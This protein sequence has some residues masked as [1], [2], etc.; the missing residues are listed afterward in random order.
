MEG[1]EEALLLLQEGDMEAEVAVGV[2]EDARNRVMEVFWFE[3]FLWIADQ[4][5]FAF[6]LRDLELLG[7]FIFPRIIIQGNLGGLLLCSLWILM[8]PQRLSII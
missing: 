8:R 2:M 3:T 5:S 4:K 7:M 6:H 1:E